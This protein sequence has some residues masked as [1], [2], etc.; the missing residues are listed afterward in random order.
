MKLLH[1]NLG[2]EDRKFVLDQT[3]NCAH[4]N[5]TS[6]YDNETECLAEKAADIADNI[7]HF[8]KDKDGKSGRGD[9]SCLSL[10]KRYKDYLSQHAEEDPETQHV[11]SQ[12]ISV[13][14]FFHAS[15]GVKKSHEK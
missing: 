5:R 8:L 14:N 11:S 9:P 6:L 12:N 13:A 15:L 2:T 10:G 1:Q 7:E 4:N 3:L